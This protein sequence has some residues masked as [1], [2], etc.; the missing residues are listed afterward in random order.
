M[1]SVEKKE[2]GVGTST[3]SDIK[4]NKDKIKR[5]TGQ[6]D[7]GPGSR[8]TL[9]KAEYTEME[10]R[11]HVPISYEILS[12]K[13][14]QF[15]T[16]TYGND[17]FAASRSWISNFRK[18]HGL[19]SLKVCGEKLSN[20]QIAV[21]PFITLLKFVMQMNLPFIRKCYLKKTLVRSQEKTAPGRKISKERITFLAYCNADGSQK[22]KLL[23]IGKAKN[24]RTF[25]IVNLPVE[26]K[27][28][29]NS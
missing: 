18:M 3:I 23:V 28:S 20:N 7:S 14:K 5:F 4:K 15:Y 17:N 29:S 2:Y 12:A 10:K 6:C 19:R 21:D 22:V 11:L 8:K 9:R 26:Y 13:A 25:K 1:K 16:E 24:P 27:S